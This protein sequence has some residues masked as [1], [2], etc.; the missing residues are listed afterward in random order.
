MAWTDKARAAAAAARKLKGRFK[1][2][3]GTTKM[4]I[5]RNMGVTNVVEGFRKSTSMLHKPKLTQLR[6]ARI[7]MKVKVITRKEMADR[8]RAGRAQVKKHPGNFFGE[9]RSG[10]RTQG[11]RV[12]AAVNHAFRSR[13]VFY[14]TT[15]KGA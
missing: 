7:N 11:E 8:L 13:N 12:K 4:L 5:G 6:A 1:K 10:R 3:F 14:Q 9:S 2:E 15:K